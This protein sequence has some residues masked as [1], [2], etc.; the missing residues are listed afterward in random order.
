[1]ELREFM[2][3][4]VEAAGALLAQRHAAHRRA[5]PLLAA[6]YE[7]PAVAAGQV[8]AAF[9]ADDASG[10]VALESGQLVG[11]LLGAPKASPAWGPNIWVESAGL[12]VTSAELARD[13]YG[14]AAAGW[15]ADGRTA[16]Y[17]LV[18]TYDAA[19]VDAWAR[20]AFGQQH[21]H[22]IREPLRERPTSPPTV[23]MRAPRRTDIEEL[24]AMDVMV[25]EHQALS[26]V[27]S[28]ALPEPYETNVADWEELFDDPAYVN[29]VAEV[30]GV[31]VGE[32]TGCSIEK[33]G[34][35]VGPAR[36]DSAGFLGFASVRPQSRGTGV[37]RALGETVLHW[38]GEAGYACVVSDWRVT[39]L[40]S[41]RAW[42]RLG[43][44]PTFVRMHRLVGY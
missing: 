43:F 35:H 4:D 33:S 17:V 44:R 41:S 21:L 27:F 18:P 23:T 15:V 38:A 39:N 2:A 32:A 12:A 3:G 11:Y 13:L 40:L 6:R 26:P 9:A 28:A 14:A 24:V 31:L 30:D 8:A 29:F 36:P 22:G 42:P 37:G 19:L 20:L 10:A 5:E 1:M 7:D 16:H 25:P 34:A